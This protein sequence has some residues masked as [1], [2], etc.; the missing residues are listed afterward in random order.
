MI[1]D[2]VIVA[3]EHIGMVAAL[4]QLHH[5]V[6]QC[7]SRHLSRVVIELQGCLV[8]NVIVYQLLPSRQ[9][10][11]YH[12]LLLL[13]QLGF[14][15]LLHPSQ[16]ERSQDLM[17]TIDDQQLLL[18]RETHCLFLTRLLG[19]GNRKPFLEVVTTVEHLGQQK[20]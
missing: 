14:H 15:L 16:Q 9:L 1:T 3:Q 18:L 5:E 10:H 13:G 4:A 7:R 11:L 6:G 19:N 12:M 2:V 20:V 17:Q 8:G